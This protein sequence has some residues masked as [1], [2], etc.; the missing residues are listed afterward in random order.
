V[1]LEVRNGQ[2]GLVEFVVSDTGIGIPEEDLGT[3]FDTF[4][5]V[6][7]SITRRYGG[8]GLG[9]AICKEL[10]ELMGGT[11]IVT[12][13]VGAGS[14]FAAR[15]PLPADRAH[16]LVDDVPAERVSVDPASAPA[17]LRPTAGAS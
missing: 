7:G 15:V 8:S 2:D 10:V 12:S 4:H 17:G 14:A 1:G 16:V 5:Q 6:D 3:V 11:L 13:E 9:L